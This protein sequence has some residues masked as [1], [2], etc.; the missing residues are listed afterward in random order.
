MG[1]EGDEGEGT[2]EIRAA[3]LKAARVQVEEAADVDEWW[4]V[5]TD[6]SFAEGRSGWGVCIFHGGKVVARLKGPVRLK[7]EPGWKGAEYHS[8]NAGELSGIEAGFSW[9]VANPDA[10]GGKILVAPDS[11]WAL[12]AARVPSEGGNGKGVHRGL[13]QRAREAREAAEGVCA[14]VEWGWVKGHEGHEGNEEADRLA[15]EGRELA[16]GG[17]GRSGGSGGRAA[18]GGR[19]QRQQ[20]GDLVEVAEQWLLLK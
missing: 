17:E 20:K 19:R 1:E 3:G 8:N 11:M 2:Q 6:G 15:D 18:A 16:R 9:V 12:N 4:R 13:A 14:T 10:R 7:G 5:Y